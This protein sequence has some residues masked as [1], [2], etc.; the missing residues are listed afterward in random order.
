MAGYLSEWLDRLSHRHVRLSLE[1][2]KAYITSEDDLLSR[3]PRLIE[4]ESIRQS[5]S[6]SSLERRKM[7]IEQLSERQRHSFDEDEH[8]S[9]V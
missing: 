4:S 8:R 2:C 9:A 5:F 3:L 1:L 7:M 6:S